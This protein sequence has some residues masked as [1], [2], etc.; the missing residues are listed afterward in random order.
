MKAHLPQMTD[1]AAAEAAD[2][3]DTLLARDLPI[4]IAGLRSVI[5]LRKKYGSPPA[6]LDGPDSYLDFSL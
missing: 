5:A 2:N 6:R 4:N 1:E 3:L